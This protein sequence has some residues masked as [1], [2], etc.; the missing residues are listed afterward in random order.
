MIDP[1]SLAGLTITIVDVLIKLGERTAELISDANA[2]ESDSNEMRH[3]VND[4]NLQTKLLRN[5]L[6]SECMVYGGKTLFEQFDSDIQRQIEL[7]CVEIKSILQ[8]SVDL[9]E[10]RYGISRES[11]TSSLLNVST[12]S[13]SRIRS[14]SSGS[15]HNLSWGRTSPSLPGLLRWSLR[16][17][18]RV[19]AILQL[20]KDRNSRLK[21]KVE[22]WCLASQLGVSPEHLMHLQTDESSRKLGFDQDASLRLAQWD[23]DKMTD[24]LE[25]IDPVWD[26]HLKE[27]QF[28]DHQGMFAMF[29]KD[30]VA[31]IQE[32]H[33]YDAS[34]TP[35]IPGHDIDRR[36]RGRIE[37]LAKLLHQPK[38]QVFRVL[39]CVGWKYLP[40]QSS[41][42]FV[43]EVQ[44]KPIGA[45]VSLQRLLFNADLRPELGDKF[46]LALGLSQCIA[47]MHMLHESF[48]SDN[49]LLLPHHV[50]LEKVGTRVTVNYPE[51]W[52]LGFEFSRPEPFFSVG[53]S[54]FEPTRDIYR[55]PDRQG[56]P[57][58]MFKKIHDIYAL[59]VVLLEIGLWEP[60]VK[61]EKNMFSHANNP[62]AVQA[63][64]IKHA[65]RRLESRVG[66]KYKEVV[67]KCLTGEF[68]VED[69][70]K[71]D[72]KLQQAFRHQIVD[73]IEMA[74]N[75][76]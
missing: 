52:V 6:F 44:P 8:E 69:D 23:A 75:Y 27:I 17:K 29:T 3:L 45:P 59:G 72:L 7:L 35:A 1:L 39:P 15:I 14:T 28:I 53:H 31:Y 61:L 12:S 68:G 47:Q 70:T 9:L 76:V 46:R 63:Q 42:A 5:L 30:S 58:E 24:S 66:K 74:A 11:S 36:T 54:D 33:H 56:Q 18:K 2:F 26:S 16:D 41:I 71:E 40:S 13:L 64:L 22:L 48:R 21:K 20:F 55:H 43:F 60:A 73:V 10:R 4:E 51:P 62:R 37:S 65:Q 57:M 34:G 19:E 32:N 38:E 25:L 67:I 50:E 49:I